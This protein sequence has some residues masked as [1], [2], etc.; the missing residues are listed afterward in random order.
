MSMFMLLSILVAP[1]TPQEMADVVSSRLGRLDNLVLDISLKLYRCAVTA[2]PLDK[3]Q[4][5]S[6]SIPGDGGH[7]CLKIVRP[8]ARDDRLRQDGT[9]TQNFSSPGRSVRRLSRP[10]PDGRTCYVLHENAYRAGVYTQVPLL[11]LFDLQIH[12]SARPGANLVTLLRDPSATIV[13]SDGDVTTYGVTISVPAPLNCTEQYEFALSG[14]GLLKRFQ[15]TVTARDREFTF[16]RELH[17]LATTQV[18]GVELPSEAVFASWNSAKPD[19]YG[20]DYIRVNSVSVDPSL[21][22]DA[23]RLEPA[24]VNERI[25]VTNADLSEDEQLFDGAGHQIALAKQAA[26]GPWR[27]TLG[28][29]AMVCAVAAAGILAFVSRFNRRAQAASG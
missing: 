1:V 2:D 12:E 11:Q 14:A 25:W 16:K 8:C 28:P 29:V 4:W 23:L 18:N 21:T 9:T 22:A 13:G 26:P 15:L 10:D 3:T 6:E 20:I 5:S 24:H 17:V 7:S 19:H 27:K